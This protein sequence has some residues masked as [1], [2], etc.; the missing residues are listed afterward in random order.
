MAFPF[1]VLFLDVDGVLNRCGK[2]FL[3][4]EQDLL[5]RL[6][7]IVGQTDCRIV[8]SST[9]R[10]YPTAM[11]E[12]VST[13]SLRG[14]SIFS[15]TPDLARQKENGIYLAKERGHEIQAWMDEHGTPELFCIVDDG[16]DMAHLKSKLVQTDCY[17]GLAEDSERAIISALTPA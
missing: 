7:S 17:T 14:I 5:D 8:L 15:C 9:W 10:L 13:F 12:L 16:S 1:P 4:L 11:K 3:R 2:S 6:V